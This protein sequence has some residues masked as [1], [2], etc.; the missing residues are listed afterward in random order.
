[1]AIAE[2][3]SAGNLEE[4]GAS[5]A[6]PAIASLRSAGKSARV[7]PLEILTGDWGRAWLL[8]TGYFFT[9][10]LFLLLGNPTSDPKHRW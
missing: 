3:R 6:P 2:L 4:V 5:W 1:M 9:P 10:S 7:L 8:A